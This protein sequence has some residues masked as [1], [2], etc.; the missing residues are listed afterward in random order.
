MQREIYFG[1]SWFRAKKRLTEKWSE[2]QAKAAHAEAKLYTVLVDSPDNPYCFVEVTRKAV[3]VGFLDS[4]LRETL[5][6]GFQEVEPGML[7][8]TMATYREFVDES[9]KVAKGTSYIF[10]ADGTVHVRDESFVPVHLTTTS[11][12]VADISGNYSKFPD[13]GRYD[14]LIRVERCHV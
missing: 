5:S 13:F 3:G 1:K 4:K 7:F 6:Y 9:D 8:L 2:A 10:K 14:D 12:R 11:Q